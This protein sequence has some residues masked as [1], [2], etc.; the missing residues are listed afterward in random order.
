MSALLEL[1]ALAAAGAAAGAVNAVAGGG[2][3]I[4]FPALVAAG[5]PPLVANVTN[6]VAVLPGY[7]G[8]SVAYRAELRGQ[9]GRVRALAATSALGAAAGTALL[10]TTPASAFERLAPALVLAASLLLAAQPWIAA[11]V[12]APP[13]DGAGRR[14]ALLQPVV[15]VAAIYGGY[16][17]AG[18]G[19]LLLAV[20]G[21]LLVDDLQRL[22]A[23]KGAL[24][25]VIGA[26]AALSVALFGP[27]AW[28]AAGV[29]ALGSLAGG[30]LGVGV[31]R[32]MAPEALRRGVVVLGVAVAVALWLSG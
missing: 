17:G 6:A 20:L 4:S 26:V 24:S 28:P 27:V 25:L 21:L 9:R 31:A 3:L 22:N 5:H 7:L 12:G 23:L 32:R 19:V 1:A 30:H 15:L 2:S 29:M 14:R 11:R 16:F 13:G 8:G 10:L 18:L